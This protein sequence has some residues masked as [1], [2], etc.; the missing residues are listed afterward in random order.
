MELYTNYRI[1]NKADNS[2]LF[3]NTNIGCFSEFTTNYVNKLD[4]S[5]FIE[6]RKMEVFLPVKMAQIREEII[7]FW[8]D[9]L[10]KIGFPITLGI[11]ELKGPVELEYSKHTKEGKN[12]LFTLDYDDYT[13]KAHIKMALHLLRYCYEKTMP[14]IATATYQYL[15]KYPEHCFW[16]AFQYICG[17]NNE[18]IQGHHNFCPGAVK[19]IQPTSYLQEQFKK[20]T[21]EKYNDCEM[22]AVAEKLNLQKNGYAMVSYKYVIESTNVEEYK[23][24]VNK[25]KE[26]HGIK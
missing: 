12:Y 4:T 14:I 10:T 26:Q 13:S 9:G 16:E 2:V 7:K 6:G 22:Y 23:K 15:K 24:Q 5:E 1:I 8:V 11:V 19:N 21:V 18:S 20:W 17:T 25:L 3:I